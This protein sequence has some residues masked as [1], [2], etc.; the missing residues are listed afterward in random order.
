MKKG[1]RRRGGKGEA[2][3]G[4]QRAGMSVYAQG[5][6]GLGRRW[7][8]RGRRFEQKRFTYQMASVGIRAQKIS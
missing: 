1:V 7:Q 6:G 4:S 2:G 8:A 3:R 5:R